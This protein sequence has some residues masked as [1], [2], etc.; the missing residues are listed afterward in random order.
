MFFGMGGGRGGSFGAH[1]GAR[2]RRRR[3]E[4]KR[5]YFMAGDSRLVATR[6]TASGSREAK[7]VRGYKALR[8]VT[9]KNYP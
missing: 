2:E 3:R 6:L 7:P 8:A 4:S 5:G 1:A 9:M